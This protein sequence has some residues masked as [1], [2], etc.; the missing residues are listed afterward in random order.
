MTWK[1]SLSN[2]EAAL[3]K[4]GILLSSETTIGTGNKR[5]LFSCYPFLPKVLI[6]QMLGLLLTV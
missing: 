3:G 5:L 4:T 2:A 6:T 1:H